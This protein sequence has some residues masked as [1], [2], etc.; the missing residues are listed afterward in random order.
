[1]S[2][3]QSENKL[4]SRINQLPEN[5]VEK[6]SDTLS[7]GLTIFRKQTIFEKLKNLSTYKKLASGG[8]AL[9]STL[10]LT[11]G[12]YA[13]LV[14][15]GQ[16]KDILRGN[17]SFKSLGMEKEVLGQKISGNEEVK[18]LAHNVA[19]AEGLAG[20]LAGT[21][22]G[23]GAARVLK[24]KDGS[25]IKIVSEKSNNNE[26]VKGQIKSES[27]ATKNSEVLLLPK[28]KEEIAADTMTFAFKSDSLVITLEN[29]VDQLCQRFAKKEFTDYAR[30]NGLSKDKDK[31]TELK[32]KGQEIMAKY[33]QVRT[34]IFE[35]PEFQ[36]KA[37][38]QKEKLESKNINY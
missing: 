17:G 16:S 11:A 1:M 23:I 4:T 27:V 3:N 7:S 24:R 18:K 38:E 9:S 26:I 22:A 6:S 2:N 15:V 10:L 14:G 5:V 8:L 37:R 34:I 25:S 21:A 12:T 29:Y 33:L 20:L 32:T 13:T 19:L 35:N 28:S 36:L 31:L 30:Q